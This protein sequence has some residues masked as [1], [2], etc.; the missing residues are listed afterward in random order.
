[1]TGDRAAAGVAR[2]GENRVFD[3]EDAMDLILWR[4][5]EAQPPSP[6]LADLDRAL[7]PK[8]ERQAR[9][10]AKWLEQVLPPDVR[11]LCSPALRTRQTAQ[12]LDRP[13]DVVSSI[14]P[15]V[16]AVAVLRA[17]N[18]PHAR[19]AVVVVGHQPTLGEAAAV[20]MAGEPQRWSI[21]KGAVWWLR[22]TDEGVHL[23]TVRSP[24]D[25]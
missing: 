25:V 6:G 17:A 5:A 1:V 11:I 24:D 7:T 8:G 13:C 21:R 20:V 23:V 10:V 3:D 19:S 9:R 2:R 22:S 12:A 14:A 16:A 18:W 15:D 4:H